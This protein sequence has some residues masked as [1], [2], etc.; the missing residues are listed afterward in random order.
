MI[1]YLWILSDTLVLESYNKDMKS[2]EIIFEDKDIIVVNKPAGMPTQSSQKKKGEDLYNALQEFLN[3]RDQK[4]V[5]LALHHRLDAATSG[6]V[7]FC[8]NK[9]FNKAITDLF[10]DK[11]IIKKY[12]A[13]VD[14]QDSLTENEWTVE[15]KL[16][17]Y[18]FKHF[19]KAKSSPKGK[20]ALTTFK[21]IKQTEKSALIECFPQTGR[22]H[23]IRVHLAQAGTP[24]QGDFHY[25]KDYKNHEFK[26]CAHALSFSHPRTKELIE[27][28]VECP[29]DLSNRENS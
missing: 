2:F 6:L 4:Q 28:K 8:K 3:N 13:I 27:L 14:I 18:R 26:L 1:N 23:Q 9:H 11:K 20:T 19:K 24:I 10:R 25:N 22:L 16:I 15:N 21:L 5:Y 12:L 7:L 17:E 29:F